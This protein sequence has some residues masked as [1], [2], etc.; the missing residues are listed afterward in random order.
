M[1]NQLAMRRNIAKELLAFLGCF[2]RGIV[3][4]PL[5]ITFFDADTTFKDILDSFFVTP[6]NRSLGYRRIPLYLL[7]ADAIDS[8][9]ILKQARLDLT[10][11]D[12]RQMAEVGLISIWRTIATSPEYPGTNGLLMQLDNLDRSEMDLNHRIYED[13]KLRLCGMKL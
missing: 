6:P 10:N 2:F 13:C 12:Q 8:L 9:R 5:K 7:S 4:I 11:H 1:S 3:V